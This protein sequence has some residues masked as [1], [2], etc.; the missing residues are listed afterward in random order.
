MGLENKKNNLLAK[1]CAGFTLIELLVVISIISVLSSIVFGALNDARTKARDAQRIQSLKEIQKALELYYNDNDGTYP[2]VDQL[3]FWDGV[4][5]TG[6]DWSADLGIRLAPYIASMP[7]DPVNDR[8]SIGFG[9]LLGDTTYAYYYTSNGA[10]YDLI[11]WFE[12]EHTLRCANKDWV[13]DAGLFA[14]DTTGRWCTG[15]DF[16]ADGFPLSGYIYDVNG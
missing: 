8:T 5:S 7:L 13:V 14:A 1:N 6:S 12:T 2:I 4:I 16:A 9:T 11:T 15:T 10:T 3:L